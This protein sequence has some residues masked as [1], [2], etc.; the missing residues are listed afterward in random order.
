[1][2]L[3]A[4]RSS[5]MHEYITRVCWGCGSFAR[6]NAHCPFPRALTVR[7][8][9][10]GHQPGDLLPHVSVST[11]AGSS[12]AQNR[13]R[14]GGNALGRVRFHARRRPPRANTDTSRPESAD[15]CPFPRAPAS[16]ARKTRHVAA[17]MRRFVSVSTRACAPARKYG[18]VAAGMC[19]FVSVFTRAG[20]PRAQNRSPARHLHPWH[21]FPRTNE[22]PVWV[23][24]LANRVS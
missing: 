15:S 22:S 3:L 23:S 18:H 19:R 12:C 5:A 13:T 16:P 8:R 6:Q 2:G 11:R 4:S 1:M 17:G 14:H 21:P 7:A 20:S 24:F 9:K 10:Q